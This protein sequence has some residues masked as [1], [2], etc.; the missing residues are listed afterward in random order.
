MK[1]LCGLL[2]KNDYFR[3]LYNSYDN[4]ILT[5]G[6]LLELVENLDGIEGGEIVSW[7]RVKD[8]PSLQEI[9]EQRRT[10]KENNTA[11]SRNE[12][13]SGTDREVG[14]SCGRK[15]KKFIKSCL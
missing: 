2:K 9:K 5:S 11:T 12:N 14:F 3:G 1:Y 7:H 10:F 6:E 13:G 4:G 8:F 15:S